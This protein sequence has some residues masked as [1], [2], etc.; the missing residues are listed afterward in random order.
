MCRNIRPLHNFEPPATGD[1]VT[2][3]ALQY[4]R[5]VSGT[6]KPSQANQAAFDRAVAEIAHVTQHLLDDLVTTAPPKDREVEAEK[7]RA[8]AALRYAR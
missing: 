7:A 1:E 5:K 6:T 2:A 8:R 4:V 3:A